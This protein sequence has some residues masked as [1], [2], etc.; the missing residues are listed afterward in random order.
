[1][2]TDLFKAGSLVGSCLETI[3]TITMGRASRTE[4]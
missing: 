1:M 4:T 2:F 3:I